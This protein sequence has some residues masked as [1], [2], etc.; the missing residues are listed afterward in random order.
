MKFSFH[1]TIRQGSEQLCWSL[2]RGWLCCVI[3]NER[4]LAASKQAAAA[5]AS[6]STGNRNAEVSLLS[7]QCLGDNIKHEFYFISTI[8][9]MAR[10]DSIICISGL[11][12]N[13]NTDQM[14]S[15]DM[16]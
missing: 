1:K 10:R 9:F 16:S 8:S 4:A 3:G 11:E 6:R 5:A 2:K 15:L 13:L 14:E 12:I 7:G